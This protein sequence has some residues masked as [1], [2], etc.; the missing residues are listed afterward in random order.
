MKASWMMYFQFL[1]PIIV[2]LLISQGKKLLGDKASWLIPA[3]A[4][5]IAELIN[6]LQSFA[7]NS[8]L[9]PGQAAVL[10]AVG[11]FLREVV[12]Q[13]R[14]SLPTGTP[15]AKQVIAWLAVG[16]MAF[17]FTACASSAIGK[18]IQAADAQKQLVERAAVEFVKLKLRGDPRITPAVYEQGKA[19][20]EKYQGAQGTLAEALASWQ[21]VKSSEN[22]SKLQTA[23]LE[24]T[25]NIDVYL[26]LVGR[27]VNLEDL[28]KKLGVGLL[29]EIKTVH[30]A[31]TYFE[32]YYSA[33]TE[34][35]KLAAQGRY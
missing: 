3:S 9:A 10:G 25:K 28:K 30:A 18:S 24:V 1:L 16:L 35:F 20:Y 26:S 7:T 2:P 23:L 19:A 27:F 34:E 15:G 4:P 21:V 13:I 8:A 32:I 17:G 12:D 11:V 5:V 22:E 14:Q 6:F 33:S 31:P 29:E